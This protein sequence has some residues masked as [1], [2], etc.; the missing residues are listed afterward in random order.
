MR[1]RTKL[2]AAQL[3]LVAALA[4]TIIVGSYV[5]DALGRGSRDIL[6]DNYR[7]VLAAQTMKEAAERIDSGV[8]FAVAGHPDEGGAQIDANIPK[9][10]TELAAQQHN[11]TEPGE[12]P[13]TKRLEQAWATYA[14]AIANV[15]RSL[16]DLDPRAQYFP[17]LLPKFLA[18]KDAAD[19]ILVMNQDAMSRKSDNA[20]RLAVRANTLQVGISLVGLVL[21]LIAS[22][23][24]T[25]RVLRPLSV[26][27][28]TARRL[29]EGDLAVRAKVS[30]KDELADLARELNTMADHLQ[31]YRQS[32]LGELLEAQLAAQATIDSLP[33]A[34]LVIGLD[35]ELRHANQAAES[36]LK[37][38]A[39]QGRNALATLDPAV[40]AIV[41]KLRQHIAG[42]H[43]TYIPKGLEEAI[44]VASPDGERALLPRAAPLYAEEGDV[45]AATIVLQDVTRLRRFEELRN[46]LVATVA[47]EFRTPLTSLRMAVHLLSEEAVGPLTR[48]Q[49]DLV[50]A[51]REECDR[52]QSIV[53]ELLDLSRIQADR[54]ELR[55]SELRSRGADPR[56]RRRPRQRSR[57]PPR[58]AALRGAARHAGDRRRPRA[59]PAR[60][61][62]PDLER[63][64]VR[65]RRR[66]HHRARRAAR[67]RDAHR[68][69]RPRAGHSRRLPAGDLREVRARPRRA[70]R[71]R[72]YR[73]LHRA[74]DRARARRRHRRR[75]HA[76]PWRDVLVHGAAREGVSARAVA[77]GVRSSRC[78]AIDR[79]DAKAS[80]SMLLI[81]AAKP[82]PGVNS[83]TN[84]CVVEASATASKAHAHA[85]RW[86]PL[87]RS[88]AAAPSARF[89]DHGT[90]AA[91]QPSIRQKNPGK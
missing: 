50:F 57:S 58:H 43:G 62:Q 26:V 13:A 65:P 78:S 82:A 73:P 41:E 24:M 51:A 16:A 2:F 63:D 68:G 55:T 22:S 91:T 85:A 72:G 44:K 29:G 46:D 88:S 3:P 84:H 45:T 15:R 64:Q 14:R 6:K 30:G 53:D 67:Q 27:G 33:D 17:D 80:A 23:I 56:G 5:T 38:H 28:Q 21:A 37:V 7:S 32:S 77:S 47:H 25:T 79:V 34:V 54:I 66:D 76:G 49:A 12:G 90:I 20:Q 31:R 11:I 40:R 35:G 70:E 83:A 19:A 59:H 9:F 10:E 18:V 8:M 74:R 52:L 1:M 87:A 69:R 36:L 60:A 61:R 75:Q 81:H 89:A 48:K 86:A 39:E 4:I 71:W 42:G